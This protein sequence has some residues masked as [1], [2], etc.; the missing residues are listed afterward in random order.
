TSALAAVSASAPLM[1]PATTGAPS[2]TKILTDAFPIPDPA[3]VMTATLP[4]KRPIACLLE[5]P[6][7]VVHSRRLAGEHRE[8]FPTAHRRRGRE[9]GVVAV[10]FPL[11]KAFQDLLESD[12]TLEA[13]QRRTETEVAAVAAGEGLVGVPVE[14]EA[15]A[16]RETMVV[17]VGGS[18]EEH[19][20][21]ARRDGPSV[22][23]D[24][25]RDVPGDMGRG[26][27]V[28]EQLFDRIRD[29]RPILDQLA[30]LVRV[31]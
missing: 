3:P 22:D 12:A 20:C 30:P 17:A 14:V 11:G 15:I 23:L 28:A 31:I 10:D 24:V 1:S 19:H 16:V 5:L 2:R 27:L 6:P 29:E 8:R 13:G 21:T 25:A 9:P 18:D 7:I 4:S 26:R